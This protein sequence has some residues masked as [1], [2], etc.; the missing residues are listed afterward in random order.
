MRD[1]HGATARIQRA[2]CE[3]IKAGRVVVHTRA[4]GKPPAELA[5][6]SIRR[7]NIATLYP[8]QGSCQSSFILS[9]RV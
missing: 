4:A 9:A 1:R 2:R 7:S 5:W 6:L 8:P 3:E